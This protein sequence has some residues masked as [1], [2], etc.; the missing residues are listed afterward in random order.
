MGNLKNRNDNRIEPL[1]AHLHGHQKVVT[2]HGGVDAVV[3]DDK[4]NSGGGR[5]HIGMVAVEEDRNVVV[6][7]QKDEGLFVHDNEKGVNELTA[8]Q[9]QDVLIFLSCRIVVFPGN[10]RILC[11]GKRNRHEMCIMSACRAK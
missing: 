7:V 11:I 10:E 9:I 8:I 6:P 4:E 2:V 1:G 5:C 3:H